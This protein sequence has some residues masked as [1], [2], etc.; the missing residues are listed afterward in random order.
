MT[1]ATCLGFPLCC[2]AACSGSGALGCGATSFGAFLAEIERYM[3]GNSIH[4]GK[5]SLTRPQSLITMLEDHRVAKA[6]K[7]IGQFGNAGC[8]GARRR[9]ETRWRLNPRVGLH[10]QIRG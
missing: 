2:L 3:A 8:G 5:R 9:R 4:Q 6:S 7:S 1:Q 10:S